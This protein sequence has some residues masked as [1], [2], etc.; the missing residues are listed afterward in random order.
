[1]EAYWTPFSPIKSPARISSARNLTKTFQLSVP[2]HATHPINIRD[3]FNTCA[4]RF[5]PSRRTKCKFCFLPNSFQSLCFIFSP[6][7]VDQTGVTICRE[8]E[9]SGAHIDKQKPIPRFRPIVPV[10]AS[11]VLGRNVNSPTTSP[12]NRRATHV[13]SNRHRESLYIGC[14][15]IQLSLHY[16]TVFAAEEMAR[17][18][19]RMT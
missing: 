4:H 17:A 6:F 18:D 7:F 3:F 8:S 1:M 13:T 15:T 11:S 5:K 10:L 19:P 16:C 2:C 14:D 9:S 12:P